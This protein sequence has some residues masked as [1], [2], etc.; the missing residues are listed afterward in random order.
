MN[1]LS[2]LLAMMSLVYVNHD[3]QIATFRI[4][5]ESTD[6]LLDINMDS[7]DLSLELDIAS[8]ELSRERVEEYINTQTAFIFDGQRSLLKVHSLSFTGDHISVQSSFDVSI[9]SFETIEI[10]NTCLLTL[11]DQ[12]NVIAIRLNDAERDFLMNSRRTMIQVTL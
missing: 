3:I 6:L 7:E 9:T 2:L 8:S 11:E 12:S 5:K 10:H 4:Y 1:L